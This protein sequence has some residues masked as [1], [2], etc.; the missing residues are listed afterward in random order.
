V[1]VLSQ[2]H[3]YQ[4]GN[5]RTGSLIASGILVKKGCPPLVLT[6]QIVIAYFNPSS[7]IKFADKGTIRDKLRLPN[8]QHAFRELLQR[9]LCA[10]WL[11]DEY[12]S[13][14]N[15]LATS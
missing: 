13:P 5:H 7:E 9:V 8:Y 14:R 4:E 15:H 2:P 12:E 6:R 11:A 1:G 10:R 3:L